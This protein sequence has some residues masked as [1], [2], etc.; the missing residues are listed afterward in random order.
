MVQMRELLAL[1]PDENRASADMKRSALAHAA[2]CE[3]KAKAIAKMDRALR[4]LT[5]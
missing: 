2:Q 3:E 4:H 1:W 5:G